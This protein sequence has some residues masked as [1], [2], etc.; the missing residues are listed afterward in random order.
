ML[1]TTLFLYV[2]EIVRVCAQRPQEKRSERIHDGWNTNVGSL[3]AIT[4]EICRTSLAAENRQGC[5][6]VHPDL[7]LLV[8]QFQW[9]RSIG[10]VSGATFLHELSRVFAQRGRN[11]R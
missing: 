8:S 3:L 7:S 6:K 1:P 2:S 4:Q 11:S 5:S 9:R 10:V